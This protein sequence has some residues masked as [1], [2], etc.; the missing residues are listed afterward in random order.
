M[1]IKAHF[2]YCSIT[3][4]HSSNYNIDKINKLQRKA[5]KIILGKDYTHLV[6]AR[7]H[8]KMLSFDENVFLQK[9]QVMY[10]IINNIAPEY[11]IS[12]RCETQMIQVQTYGQYPPKAL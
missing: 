4:G 8:L 7:N 9:A 5:C 11:L 3:W 1:H 2:D 10:K 6:E 12:F